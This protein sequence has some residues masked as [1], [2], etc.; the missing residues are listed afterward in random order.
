Q[1]QKLHSFPTRRSSDLKRKR[2]ARFFMTR[3]KIA[4]ARSDCAISG[5]DLAMMSPGSWMVAPTRMKR[6]S[7]RGWNENEVTS[8]ISRILIL[9]SEE[10]T[11]ELQSRSDLV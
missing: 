4:A 8:S 7:R 3:W 11:S 2:S 6:Q 1:H 9:R 10:H 5:K